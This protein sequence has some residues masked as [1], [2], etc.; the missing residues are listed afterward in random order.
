MPT[1]PLSALDPE[2][3]MGYCGVAWHDWH[4]DLALAKLVLWPSSAGPYPFW[5]SC[6]PAGTAVQSSLTHPQAGLPPVPAFTLT[7]GSSSLA[8]SPQSSPTRHA[9]SPGSCVCQQMLWSS[10]RWSA[11]SLGIHQQVLK[12]GPSPACPSTS[13]CS[14]AAHL[15]PALLQPSCEL[16]VMV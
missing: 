12:L 1:A 4:L 10:L 13:C 8:R 3:T 15:S 14:A 9:P 16:A 7:S 6:T 11:A 2:L 5:L